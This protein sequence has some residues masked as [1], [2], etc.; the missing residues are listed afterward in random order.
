MLKPPIAHFNPLAQVNIHPLF[1]SHQCVV[2]DDFLLNPEEIVA[3]ASQ[4]RAAFRYDHDNYFPGL[5]MNMG[6][7]FA[8]QFE[9]FFM[10]KLRRYFGVRRNLG[11]ACRLSMTTLQCDQLQPLQRL[12]HRDAETLPADMG[13][14]AS[15]VYLFDQPELGGTCFFR[16]LQA[17][18][19]I[20]GFLQQAAN[21]D[22]AKLDEQLR[23]APSYCF[24]SN[25]W[26]ELRHTI[27][28][29]WNRAIFYEGT[30]FHAAHITDARLL[31]DQVLQSRLCLNAFFRFK[32]QAMQT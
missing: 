4:S 10:L 13:I 27:A 29:K 16:P 12:C 9:Q 20:R 18:D 3:Y 8:L 26:F 6:R 17:L 31:S 24:Q 1:D 22:N 28:A 19:T 23:Q 2:I 30:V 15:V 5:E 21:E 32:K 11:S 14:G 7:H 25:P